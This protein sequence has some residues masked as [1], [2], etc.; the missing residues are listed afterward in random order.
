MKNKFFSLI[1]GLILTLNFSSYSLCMEDKDFDD[2]RKLEG[3]LNKNIA[4]ETFI[5]GL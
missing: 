4:L 2:L 5:L 3:F 1:I